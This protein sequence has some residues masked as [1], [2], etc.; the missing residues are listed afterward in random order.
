MT[1]K[2]QMFAFLDN[3]KEKIETAIDESAI[4]AC[5]IKYLR[6][7]VKDSESLDFIFGVT[8][9][10]I[11]DVISYLLD[12]SHLRKVKF[13]TPRVET[14]YL[15]RNPSEYELM[16]A[17]RP[18]GYYTHLSAMYFHELINYQPQSIYFNHEQ[19]ARPVTGNLEQSRIDNAFKKKQRITTSKTKY[20]KKEYWLLNGKQT[21]NYGVVPI[22][23]ADNIQIAVTD[24]ERTLID[25]TVRPAYAGGVK[26]VLE[27]Y[28]SAQPKVSIPKLSAT[29][30]ALNYIYPYHQSIGFYI[31]TA[32]NYSPEDIQE[33]ANYKTFDFDFYLDYEMKD[34]AYS[35][36]WR[37][38]YP[39][40]L[41]T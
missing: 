31:E 5:G 33:F 38:Y 3:S 11:D 13:L 6:S 36:R 4:R 19:Q 20:D 2:K 22:K 40:D 17:L 34:P 16:S 39:Q 18:K 32:G 28:K 26:S 41:L 27:A 15:W 24:L 35:N 10:A 29:L 30:H 21:G 8:S 12:K 37:I 7:V 9:S 25:I 23:T 14:L 1:T